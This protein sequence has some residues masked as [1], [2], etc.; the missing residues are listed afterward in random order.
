[1]RC[2]SAVGKTAII[3]TTSNISGDMCDVDV[4]LP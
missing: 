1:M 3:G 2:G 4:N